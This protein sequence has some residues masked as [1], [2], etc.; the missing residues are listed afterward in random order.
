MVGGIPLSR[1]ELSAAYTAFQ[2]FDRDGS[3]AID[4]KVW[5]PELLLQCQSPA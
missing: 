3:G 4:T 5:N 2:R 1:E